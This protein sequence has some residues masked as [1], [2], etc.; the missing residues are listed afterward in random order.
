VAVRT[1]GEVCFIRR[2]NCALPEGAARTD[3][4]VPSSVGEV[5]TAA[6][7]LVPRFVLVCKTKLVAHEGRGGGK[8]ESERGRTPRNPTMG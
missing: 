5:A 4:F 8:R 7:L 1:A 6:Q 3:V 2:Q